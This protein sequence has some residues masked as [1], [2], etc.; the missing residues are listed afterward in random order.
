MI[1]KPEIDIEPVACDL[2]IVNFRSRS[3]TFASVPSGAAFT[4]WHVVGNRR[5]RAAP[6]ILIILPR[7]C[8]DFSS[9]RR[10]E[11]AHYQRSASPPRSPVRRARIRPSP[12]HSR[13]VR[14]VA[15]SSL[16]LGQVISAAE[17]GAPSLT[18]RF[19]SRR[20]TPSR[21]SPSRRRVRVACFRVLDCGGHDERQ[22]ARW[23]GN[24]AGRSR[25]PSPSPQP[26]NAS[27]TR[28]RTSN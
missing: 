27:R 23:I 18:A 6:L 7:P 25:S 16:S 17:N 28:N 1:R 12:I 15:S 5:D 26:A 11:S 10:V 13:N 4:P 19:L 21:W 20:S 2:L 8:R 14:S 9:E 3:C 22:A 24:A